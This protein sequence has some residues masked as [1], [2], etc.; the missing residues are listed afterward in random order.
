MNAC[1]GISTETLGLV[2]RFEEAGIKTIQTVERLRSKLSEAQAWMSELEGLIIDIKVW[3]IETARIIFGKTGRAMIFTLPKDIRK[4]IQAQLA[5][6]NDLFASQYQPAVDYKASNTG[7][8]VEKLMEL[9]D[10][11]DRIAQR[12]NWD[13][14]DRADDLRAVISQHRGE[15]STSSE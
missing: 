3:D 12:N 8:P 2:S 9:A 10:E 14:C 1:A 6:D 11:W 5:Q 15:S 7:V 13:T 4:R